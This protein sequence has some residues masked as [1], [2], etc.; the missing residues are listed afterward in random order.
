MSDR[1]PSGGLPAQAQ[2]L[3]C[4]LCAAAL[5]AGCCA[6][7]AGCCALLAGCAA[8]RLPGPWQTDF[9]RLKQQRAEQAVR[10]F[11]QYRDFAEYQAALHRWEQGDA[12]TCSEQIGK[13]LQRNPDHCPARLL[14]AEVYLVQQRE[15][16]A[17]AEVQRVLEA[18]PRN[19]EAH[20]LMGLVLDAQGRFA[21]A[22]QHYRRAAELEPTED[23]YRLAYT[24][25]LPPA[26][27]SPEAPRR[28]S[29]EVQAER[30]AHQQPSPGSA[31]GAR[32]AP[33][34]FHLLP[35][36]P[37]AS[38]E[39]ATAPS[40]RGCAA[41]SVGA[42]GPAGFAGFAGFADSANAA[43]LAEHHGPAPGLACAESADCA[44]QMAR[45]AS[46]LRHSPTIANRP[47]GGAA[48]IAPGASGL[49]PVFAASF[50]G[51]AVDGPAAG[52]FEQARAA[53][54][55]GRV[56]EAEAYLHQ[57]EARDPHNPQI[58][59]AA[60]VLA[61][62]H[63]QPELGLRILRGAKQRFPDSAAL[64]RQLA[65]AHYRLGDY[66]AAQA[67]LEDALSLDNSSALSYFLL[68]CTLAKLGAHAS[69][70]ECF[71]QARRID[72]QYAARL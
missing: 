43:Q 30:L 36:P 16:E 29:A 6:L 4:R 27:G 1:R 69:A 35:P 72:P 3:P 24:L 10:E 58:P 18:E 26:D 63:G 57:A 53:L 33:S 9:A 21:E 68:G 19:A 8:P 60:G 64:D 12:Q 51:P 54:Q 71:R 48:Q 59:L 5:L 15:A 28:A 38:Y 37:A 13:L 62:K 66:Q 40:E 11:E 23:R 45:G 70:E 34:A 2:K 67:A 50:A 22:Q 41:G 44:A 46:S 14:L 20:H 32:G 56:A 25:A 31:P 7:L 49:H 42:V 61:L 47:T 17:L 52:I 65:V 39:A 55:A